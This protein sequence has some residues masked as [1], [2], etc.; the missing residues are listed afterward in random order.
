KLSTV[1]VSTVLVR[2]WTCQSS[3]SN[4]MIHSASPRTE[5]TC[6]SAKLYRSSAYRV[7]LRS[8]SSKRT[9]PR[10]LS[11]SSLPVISTRLRLTVQSCSPGSTCMVSIGGDPSGSP[12]DGVGLRHRRET[13]DAPVTLGHYYLG[14]P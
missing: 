1:E 7:T 4:P 8:I 10:S 13:W 14:P 2:V 6:R 5:F 12:K 11:T 9:T 3:R